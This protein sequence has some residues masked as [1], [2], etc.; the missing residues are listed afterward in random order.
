M[1]N[2][3]IA[4]AILGLGLATSTTATAQVAPDSSA[5]VL[6]RAGRI[7]DSERGVMVPDQDILVRGGRIEAVGT[8]L[9][10]T[11]GAEVI[12][13]RGL[14]VL[15]GLIDAH[16]HLFYLEHPR[17]DLSLGGV[18]SLILEGTALRA[19]R[20]AARAM[21]FLEAGFTTL[22]DLGNVG[23]Y[24]DVALRTAIEEGSL[25]GPRLFVSGPGLSP[26]GG[27]FPGIV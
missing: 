3:S 1:K 2:L 10:A 11:P 27:Q 9:A 7:F 14:T 17:E 24:A 19:L 25:P 21:T 23:P 12:D 4:A 20:A 13:L 16:T 6:L 8:D 22:R 18:K 5:V 15:P 26:P